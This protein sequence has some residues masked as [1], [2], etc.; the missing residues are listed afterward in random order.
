AFGADAVCKTQTPSCVLTSVAE[1][2]RQDG[3]K[4]VKGGHCA[5]MA[6][7][8]LQIF[9]DTTIMPGDFETGAE[10]TFELDKENIRRQIAFFAIT[11]T[12]GPADTKPLTDQG[13]FSWSY[14]KSTVEVLD[15]LAKNL[16]D[17]NPKDR[18]TLGMSK[19][20]G[21]GGHEVTP[22]AVEEITKDKLYWIYVYD[23]NYPNDFKRIVKVTTNGPIT[24]AKTTASWVYEGAATKPGEPVSNYKG[25][26]TKNPIRISSLKWY[27]T[28]PKKCPF[29]STAKTARS[30]SADSDPYRFQ[31]D[32]EG[33]ILVTRNDGKRIGYDLTTGDQINEISG[34]F[35]NIVSTGFGYNTPN[36]FEIPHTS[37][38]TY[39]IQLAN[40]ESTFGLMA[41]N[42][43]LRISGPGKGFSLDGLD[44]NN[45]G[46]VSIT[47]AVET[48]SRQIAQHDVVTVQFDPDN[49]S[50]NFKASA[51]DG[52]TP[53]IVM[54]IDNRSG[55]DFTFEV[56]DAN[57]S[58][59]T[60]LDVSFDASTQQLTFKDNDSST[61]STYNVTAS[62]INQDGTTDT[63]QI[64]HATSS[65]GPGGMVDFEDW[66]GSSA[67]N[68]EQI[69]NNTTIFLP[70][71][72]R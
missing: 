56:K 25:T 35:F 24:D 55:E 57:I 45:P 32:G 2:Y 44:L 17:S 28:L 26:P 49:N 36:S 46:S 62:R 71:V 11:Q 23:N 19:L 7:S 70:L 20:D 59:G 63:T 10:V 13:L 61:N 6:K 8:S 52:D 4:F 14:N 51:L 50:V 72:V 1:K 68:V 66:D 22:Y 54:A 29:C 42:V 18:Y 21:T 58:A 47:P 53:D 12:E 64:N 48:Q 31:L 38:A 5:G 34:A 3:L 69:S 39:T 30:A 67:L 60:E 65:E 43:D 40:R 16:A 37:G 33:Y 9:F 41:N 15:I 27:T